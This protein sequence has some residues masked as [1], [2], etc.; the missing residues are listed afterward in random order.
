[1]LNSINVFLQSQRVVRPSAVVALISNFAVTLPPAYFL[2]RPTSL[3]FSGAPFALGLG[4][5]VQAVM[6][7]VIAPRVI[8]I[9]EVSNPHLK[10]SR[11][12]SNLIVLT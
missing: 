4:Q 9:K 11:S 7:Y 6:L 3:G 2:T 8:T 1:M 5:L 12:S 10:S